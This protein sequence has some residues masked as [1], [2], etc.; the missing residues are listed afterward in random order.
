MNNFIRSLL[1][2]MTLLTVLRLMDSQASEN[3]PKTS[4]SAV[5]ILRATVE[6]KVFISQKGAFETNLDENEGKIRIVK[7]NIDD[8]LRYTITKE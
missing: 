8:V 6:P 2:L 7:E 1:I 3:G 5:L 4:P